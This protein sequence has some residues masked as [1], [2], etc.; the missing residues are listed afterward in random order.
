MQ[1]VANSPGNQE[2]LAAKLANGD[3]AAWGGAGEL[4]LLPGAAVPKIP[5]LV[6]VLVTVTNAINGLSRSTLSRSLQ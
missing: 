4:L 5:V 2:L 6:M 3:R 1:Y